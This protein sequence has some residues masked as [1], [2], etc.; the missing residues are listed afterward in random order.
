MIQNYIQ[1]KKQIEVLNNISSPGAQFQKI[2]SSSRFIVLQTRTPGKNHY[3]YIGRGHG[4]EG[5]WISEKPLPAELRVK[6]KFLDYLRRY[7]RNRRFDHF[8]LDSK[9]R[10][11]KISFLGPESDSFYIFYRG[12]ELYFANTDVQNLSG[13][14]FKSWQ[15][16]S[17]E[18]ASF[19]IFDEVGRTNIEQRVEGKFVNIEE[20]I[21]KEIEDNT[22]NF[23]KSTKKNEKKSQRKIRNINKDLEKILKWKELEE[24]IVKN[25]LETLNRKATICG[26]KFHFIKDNHYARVSQVY[27][28]IKRLKKIVPFMQERLEKE[29]LKNTNDHV[30]KSNTLSPVAP[31]W[32]IIQ[33]KS[34]E[35]T[36]HTHEFDVHKFESCEV[37]V[38]KS[39]KGNDQ[40]RSKWGSKEDWWVHDANSPSAHVVIKLKKE[41]NILDI[42]NNIVEFLTDSSEIDIIYTKLK[43]VK[44]IKGSPG[45]VTYKKEKRIRLKND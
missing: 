6:D 1:L 45:K 8:A 20:L 37:G 10:I 28:K 23:Q 38:G 18:K 7:V 33:N 32:K 25:N 39:A 34:N 14:T 22:R 16:T 4:H 21:E 43:N 35:N 40:L 44:S 24:F 31:V 41:T 27:D 3:I 17:E 30:V 42:L 13:R 15:G 19:S 26:F 29:K 9:D 5:V 11:F 2:T 36:G 12:R